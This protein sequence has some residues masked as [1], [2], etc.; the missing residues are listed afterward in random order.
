MLLVCRSKVVIVEVVDVAGIV[1]VMG[2]EGRVVL[3]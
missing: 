1:S 2:V 3:A